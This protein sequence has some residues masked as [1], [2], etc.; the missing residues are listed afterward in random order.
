MCEDEA[1][2]SE[3]ECFDVFCDVDKGEECEM[4]AEAKSRGRRCG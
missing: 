2:W 1:C 3:R 4:S